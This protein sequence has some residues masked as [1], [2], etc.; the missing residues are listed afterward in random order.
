MATENLKYRVRLS[1]TVDKGLYKAFYNASIDTRIPLSRM[2][3]DAIEDYL[4]KNNVEYTV[5]GPYKKE[6]IL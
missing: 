4:K 5:D 6:K 2:L 1:T 3:D